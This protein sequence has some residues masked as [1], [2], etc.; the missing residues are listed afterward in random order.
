VSDYWG[1]VRLNDFSFNTKHYLHG[2]RIYIGVGSLSVSGGTNMILNYAA[3][4]SEAGAEVTIGH[5][6]G[7]ASDISWHPHSEKFKI[8]SM[9]KSNKEFYDLGIMTWWAT[10]EPMLKLNCGKFLYFVQSLESRFALNVGDRRSQLLAASTYELALPVVTVANWLANLLQAQTKSKVWF[11][12]NGIDK[13]IFKP[14]IINSSVE[15]EHPVFLIEGALDVP[16]KAVNETLK[17]LREIDG[18]E[19]WHVNPSKE[20]SVF[21]DKTFNKVN[22]VDM[23]LIY[24]KSDVLIKMSRVEGMFGPPLEGFH[25]GATA[26]VSKVTGHD[27]YIVDGYNSL[28]VEVDDF[29]AMKS[30]VKNLLNDRSLLTHLK[31]G[32][33]KTAQSWPDI[34]NSSND[35]VTLCYL[36]LSSS[37]L[38]SKESLDLETFYRLQGMK[39]DELQ[40]S[41]AWSILGF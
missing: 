3:A 19:I 37:T 17:I 26:I 1:N 32:A 8:E 13:N 21:A 29:P 4:L 11:I 18:I 41:P 25:C 33:L 34:L 30:K 36:V 10:V 7:S 16:M 9:Q 28:T 40:E 20:K 5:V 39:E 12:K 2:T 6:L 38:G 31:Q 15:V 35:F 27:E 14:G 24:Q 22:F 23:P